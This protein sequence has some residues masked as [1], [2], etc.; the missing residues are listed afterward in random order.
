MP[1]SRTVAQIRRWIHAAAPRLR[2]LSG[3]RAEFLHM[4]SKELA[5]QVLAALQ[6]S[7]EPSSLHD[8]E[9]RVF[10]QYGEDGIIN[11]LS[12]FVI[13]DEQFFVEIG[14]EDYN[15]ANTRFLLS[16]QYWR[17]VIIDA[18]DKH[19]RTVESNP[20]RWKYGVDPV[21]AF[22]E[23]STVEA[24][25]EA[26]R[27]PSTI[28]LLSIDVD[29][30]D[31]WILDAIRR[32]ARIVVVEYNSLFGAD[33]C[34][35]VPYS[36]GFDRRAHHYST[37]YFG[38]SLAAFEFLLRPRGYRLIGCT[39]AGNNAFF[40][41]ARLSSPLKS[42]AP[43]EAFVDGVFRQARNERGQLTYRDAYA[44]ITDD[45]A[46]LPLVDVTTGSSLDL[47]SILGR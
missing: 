5:G 9:F 15:E 23:P 38:A 26:A 7:A 12:R 29:G 27:V 1:S 4:E 13:P 45:L 17:G 42:L 10:S 21:V 19:A 2:G 3:S 30:M 24:T 35:T 36:P 32:R 44:S 20:L 40:V 41:D 18:H 28:G 25:L 14:V 39:S 47:G 37:L 34:V 43:Q 46:H 31:Y 11:Y 16:H 33:A 22:V 6:A 8:L